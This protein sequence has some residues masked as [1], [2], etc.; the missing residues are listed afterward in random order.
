MG[1]VFQTFQLIPYLNTLENVL[2]P[3][4]AGERDGIRRRAEELLEQLGLRRRSAHRPAELSAGE[5]QRAALAR[6]MLREPDVLLAD[7]PT[8]N[9]DAASAEQVMDAFAGF[10]GAGGTVIMVTHD[11]RLAARAGRVVHLSDGRVEESPPASA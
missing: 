4:L 11:E 5:R 7:E 10:Q 2:V 1:F 8:G 9:L 3:A 6:A